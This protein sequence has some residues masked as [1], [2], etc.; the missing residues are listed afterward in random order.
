M[1]CIFGLLETQDRPL[2]IIPGRVFSTLPASRATSPVDPTSSV[3]PRCCF[4]RFP[5][6]SA[7]DHSLLIPSWAAATASKWPLC[8][9]QCVPLQLVFQATARELFLGKPVRSRNSP[10]WTAPFACPLQKNGPVWPMLTPW[11]PSPSPLPHRMPS[12]RPWALLSPAFCCASCVAHSA[13]VC[14]PPSGLTPAD[15]SELS[16][17]GTYFKRH[18]CTFAVCQALV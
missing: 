1:S 10:A 3:S 5:A 15:L 4:S 14:F 2:G 9:P 18:L 6:A 8:P 13:S 12:T 17:N 16:L 7:S 11:A